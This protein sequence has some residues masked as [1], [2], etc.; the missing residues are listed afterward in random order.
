MALFT[1]HALS[2][3]GKSHKGE[4]DARDR[5]DALRQ[6]RRDGLSPVSLSGDEGAIRRLLA[7]E[8]GGGKDCHRRR[9]G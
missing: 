8:V 4:L 2:A 1:Y 9:P 7:M 6:L 3:D 5:M